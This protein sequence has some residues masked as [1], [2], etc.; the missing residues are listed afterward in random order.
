[1]T[2]TK[3]ENQEFWTA[4]DPIP[5]ERAAGHAH[6]RGREAEEEWRREG[7]FLVV[8]FGM[9]SYRVLTEHKDEAA[10]EETLAWIQKWA[11]RGGLVIPSFTRDAVPHDFQ[12]RT[13]QSLDEL[14]KA[15]LSS[16]RY[17]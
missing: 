1:M 15:I 4:L 13:Q 3:E 11:K 2:L 6:P 9:L 5:W 14:T 17:E 10:A 7:T 8:F 16:Y 12:V